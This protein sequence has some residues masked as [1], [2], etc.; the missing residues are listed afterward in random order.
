[1]SGVIIV[2]AGPGGIAAAVTAA[3]AGAKVTVLDDNVA[4]GGQIWRGGYHEYSPWIGRLAQSTVTLVNGV[5]VVSGDSDRRTLLLDHQGEAEELSYSKLI[6][7]TG[8]RELFLPFPGWTLP[9]VMGVGGLQALVKCGLPISNK[10]IVVAGSGPLLLAVASYLR[11]GGAAV[12]LIAEQTSLRDLASF[13]VSLAAAHPAKLWQAVHLNPGPRYRSGCWIEAALGSSRVEA[14]RVRRG[15]RAWEESC[16]YVANSY[17]F[18]ANTELAALLGCKVEHGAVKVDSSQQTSV[19]DIYCVG[20]TAGI[21]GVD[22][23]LVEGQVAGYAACGQ[24]PQA[25]RLQPAR[26]KARSFARLLNHTFQ[27]RPEL[28][29]LGQPDTIVCRCEDVPLA[30]LRSADSW[31]SAKLH[32]RC[33]MGPCQGRICGPAT[34]FILGWEPSS[35]RPPLFPTCLGNL[36]QE[37]SVK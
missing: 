26:R 33:G 34:Q 7:A 29:T 31:R 12:P 1:M 3:Q 8:A 6:L 28:R 14:V 10:R 18:V 35:V 4:V 21:G 30:R 13:T 20:E 5:R 19:G 37:N 15:T 9:N 32:E 17:G 16:D 24:L 23:A 36:L 2:G 11:K 27:P 22:T 25:S